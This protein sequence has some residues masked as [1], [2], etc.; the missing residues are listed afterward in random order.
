MRSLGSVL[1]NMLLTFQFIDFHWLL[2][3]VKPIRK[4]ISWKII[5]FGVPVAPFSSECLQHIFFF[6]FHRFFA[7]INI[8]RFFIYF[9]HGQE[10]K[11]V[12]FLRKNKKKFQKYSD[13]IQ[14]A[15]T[16]FFLVWFFTV[17]DSGQCLTLFHVLF[18]SSCSAWNYFT[19]RFLLNEII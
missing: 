10:L 16:P 19:E 7:I 17:R 4:H 2:Y 9:L 3:H 18:R 5:S 8:L 12:A 14:S 1:N 13:P 15:M 11:C 6:N